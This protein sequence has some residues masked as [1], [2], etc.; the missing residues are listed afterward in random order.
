MIEGTFGEKNQCQGG[1]QIKMEN[2][3][4][5]YWSDGK[6]QES[7]EFG[8]SPALSEVDA[9]SR[10]HD[11]A[12]AH[13][14]D[15][16]HRIAA[17]EI[18][19]A[20]LKGLKEKYAGLADVP[21]YGNYIKNRAKEIGGGFATGVKYGGLAG[22]LFSLVYNGVKGIVRSSDLIR[23][24]ERYRNEVLGYYKTDPVPKISTSKS[25]KNKIAPVAHPRPNAP[26][27]N[28]ETV[29]NFAMPKKTQTAPEPPAENRK[30][31]TAWPVSAASEQARKGK[32]FKK[33]EVVPLYRPLR[34]K[35]LPAVTKAD[36]VRFLKY[37]PEGVNR[38]RKWLQQHPNT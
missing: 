21:L 5:P 7:V 17:D 36:L 22:G 9:A 27:Q 12:Y 32:H 33:T 19:S 31:T 20:T 25:E 10:L 23:N 4:G 16:A 38:V 14:T 2:Y 11:S 37:N 26:L 15:E 35:P 18:Y 6:W 24:G 3:I 28:T 29:E 30:V 13:Y 1:A 8:L 34:K